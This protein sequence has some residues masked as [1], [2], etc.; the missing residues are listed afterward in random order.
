MLPASNRGAGSSLGFPDVCMTPAGPAV[1]P[2]PYPNIAM[3]AQA[4]AFSPVVK[5][6]GVNALNQSSQI[7]MTSGDEAGTAHPVI[8]GPSTYT[9][10]NPIVHIDRLPAINLTCPTTGNNMNNALGAVVVPSATNVLYCR[11][12]GASPH[13]ML[14]EEWLPE[15]VLHLV[16][17]QITASTAPAIC[18]LLAR[19][20]PAAIVLDLR[21]NP[22]GPLDAAIALSRLFLPAGAVIA[23]V[24]EGDGDRTTVRSDEKPPCVLPLAVLVDRG[25]ASAAELVAASLQDH[26]RALLVGTRTYGKRTGHRVVFDPSGAA[27]HAPAIRWERASG[28]GAIVPDAMVDASASEDE[29]LGQAWALVVALLGD[30]TSPRPAEGDRRSRPG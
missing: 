30:V 23:Y 5:V 10:G 21:D 13:Q 25:T 29:A 6:S 18:G 8:K 12:E 28:P 16:V 20:D 26:D 7:P 19:R 11:R 4:T 3:N 14:E 2:V 22:G 1:V 17:S 9:M 24:H 15:G 27:A